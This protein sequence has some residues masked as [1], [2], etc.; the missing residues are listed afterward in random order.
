MDSSLGSSAT[1]GRVYPQSPR[2]FCF[3]PEFNA[4]QAKR[5]RSSHPENARSRRPLRARC[6]R[7]D[8][9]PPQNAR[10][11]PTEAQ[12]EASSGRH[13]SRQQ[14]ADSRRE[15]TAAWAQLQPSSSSMFLVLTSLLPCSFLGRPRRFLLHLHLR[16]SL[17]DPIGLHLV[18]ARYHPFRDISEFRSA[19]V[20]RWW[21]LA[22]QCASATG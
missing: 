17:G 20:A 18:F 6:L 7:K 4:L 3:I 12:G 1:K 5:F 11:P 8:A 16:S 22:P 2:A 14:R 21:S 15:W 13:G 19:A 9:R 10:T